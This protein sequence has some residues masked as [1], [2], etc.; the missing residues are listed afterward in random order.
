MKEK[1][2]KL[3]ISRK[4]FMDCMVFRTDEEKKSCREYLDL[5]G[6]SYHAVLVGL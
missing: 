3:S 4:A 1:K 5:K 6:V 2:L